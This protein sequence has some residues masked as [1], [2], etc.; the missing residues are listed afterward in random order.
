MSLTATLAAF[1]HDCRYDDLPAATRRAAARC[2]L[3]HVGCVVGGMRTELGQKVAG[4]VTGWGGQPQATVVACKSQTP[5]PMA[6]LANGTAA[7]ALDYDDTLLG[8]PGATVCAAALAV[9]E[10]V[11]A[12][13]AELLAAITVGYEVCA[14][15]AHYW[16]PM[17]GRYTR[18]WDTATLQT[19]GTA[20]AAAL[21]LDLDVDQIQQALGIGL[22]T[23]PSPRA[24]A[25]RIDGQRRP[26]LKSAWGW[27]AEAGVR[28]ALLADIGLTAPDLALDNL[29]LVWQPNW[30]SYTGLDS[31]TDRVGE[32][33]F[34]EQVEFKPYPACRFLHSTL[35]A[36]SELISRE[37]IA[38]HDVS[39]VR[40]DSFKLLGDAFHD[41]P[42]PTSR[43]EAQFSTPFCI[44]AMLYYGQLTP[45][46]FEPEALHNADVLNLAR[47]VHISTDPGYEHSFPERSGARVSIVFHDSRSGR[48]RSVQVAKDD[49]RG[50]VANPLDDDTLCAKFVDLVEPLL[51]LQA[52]R[53]TAQELLHIGANELVGVLMR[54]FA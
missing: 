20:C 12:R 45:A 48:K 33:F 26:I 47:R 13:V 3:D 46:A 52:A 7:N 41:I 36:V 23:A 40:V 31:P 5:A 1:T 38:W 30:L 17:G 24:R 8:H 16:Q 15:L 39:E 34:I 49:P 19:F 11:D 28:A 32:Y 21:L 51:G 6:A 50:T 4:L 9:G 18:V 53:D 10:M 27:A 44:A 43:S 29:T 14:R 2:L 22:T 37:G 25:R 42:A 35:D 54:R